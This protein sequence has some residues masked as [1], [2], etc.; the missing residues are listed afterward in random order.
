MRDIIE[1]SNKTLKK[2]IFSNVIFFSIAEGGAMGEPGGIFF[3]DKEGQAYHCNYV[4]GDV[5][6][7][8][9]EKLFPTLCDCEFGMFGLD[10]K[11]PEGWT[12]VNLGMGNHLIVNDSVYP[13]FV[14][15]LGDE[16]EPS[17]IY[18]KWVEIADIILN[19]P[20]GE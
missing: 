16:E 5:N 4:F 10:S 8:K 13:K 12:Y 9:V 18:G 11:V 14:D 3:F 6:I 15:I 19:R 20:D 7:G 1:L 2:S 17:V